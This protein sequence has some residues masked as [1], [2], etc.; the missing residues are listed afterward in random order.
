MARRANTILTPVMATRLMLSLRKAA[1]HLNKPWSLDT[2]ATI[3]LRVPAQ[4]RVSYSVQ[5]THEGLHQ[6]Q[7]TLTAP[8]AKDIELN[9]VPPLLQDRD[10]HHAR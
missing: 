7:P 2:M 3:N 10:S 8:N 1:V 5:W 4:D 9:P 6:I